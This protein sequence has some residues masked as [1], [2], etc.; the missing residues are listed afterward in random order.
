LLVEWSNGDLSQ[1][2]L[3]RLLRECERDCERFSRPLTKNPRGRKP[4]AV[5][6]ASVGRSRASK[7]RRVK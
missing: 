5:V 1:S 3:L 4:V 2:P 6:E 7:L